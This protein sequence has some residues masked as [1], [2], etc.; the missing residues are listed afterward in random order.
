[1]AEKAGG[2]L[3]KIVPDIQKS[4]ELMQEIASASREQSIGT[5]QVT[6]AMTQLD[7]VIQQNASASEE[8]AASSEELTGQ[9][10]ELQKAVAF[11]VT[12]RGA[13]ASAS[14]KKPGSKAPA[15]SRSPASSRAAASA[16]SPA[17]G[18]APAKGAPATAIA[19]VEDDKDA[20]FETF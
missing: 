6:K 12:G 11:F 14:A 7:T 3:A 4:A 2:L 18:K 9:A 8:L 5:D 13:G 15:P 17:A 1:M 10:M 16:L 19:A 20:E